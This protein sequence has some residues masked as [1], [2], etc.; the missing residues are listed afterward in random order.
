[1]KD[2]VDSLERSLEMVLAAPAG[3]SQVATKKAREKKV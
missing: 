2:G 3:P 1:V